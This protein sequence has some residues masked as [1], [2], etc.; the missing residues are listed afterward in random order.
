MK[1][2]KQ[3]Y[4][5]VR[6]KVYAEKGRVIDRYVRFKNTGCKISLMPSIYLLIYQVRIVV[7]LTTYVK[8][9]ILRIGL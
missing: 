3:G 7:F 8:K 1:K 2:S 6:V 4:S 5:S 9:W